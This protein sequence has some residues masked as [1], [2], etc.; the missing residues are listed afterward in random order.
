MT[1]LVVFDLD[2]TLIDSRRD[3]ADSANLL[4]GEC[5]GRRLDE[6]AIV[7]MVGEG[8]QVLVERALA[9]AGVAVVPPGA[10]ARFSEI[11]GARLLRETR[12]YPGVPEML[13]RAARVAPLAVLTNKPRAA[14]R[15]ILE[16]LGLGR[17]FRDIYGGDGPCPRKPDARGLWQL[18]ENAGASRSAS[19]LVGDSPIDVETG[20]AAGVPVCLAR[21][22]FGFARVTASML[23]GVRLS[24]DSP[25]DLVP[26]L[27]RA[28]GKA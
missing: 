15:A 9:A 8:V 4:V 17:F 21:Y 11:Y 2:G 3:L 12:P 19:L 16:G 6:A 25:L 10:V 18:I 20:R 22:G 7:G 1:E 26:L 28:G 23:A 14:S 13:D 5:G 27:D 24:V